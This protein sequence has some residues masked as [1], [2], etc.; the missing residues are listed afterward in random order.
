MM[1]ERAIAALRDDALVEATP[2]LIRI[3]KR[4]LDPQERKSP[5]RK[6]EAA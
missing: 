1:L 6:A 2:R 5:S 4:F 3:R